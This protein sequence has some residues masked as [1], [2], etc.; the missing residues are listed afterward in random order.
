[1][2]LLFFSRHVKSI[3]DGIVGKVYSSEFKLVKNNAQNLQEL[4]MNRII[5]SLLDE[6]YEWKISENRDK[7]Y[8]GLHFGSLSDYE[9]YSIKSGYITEKK[10]KYI[11]VKK[12]GLP[13]NLI[14]T[15]NFNT[16][17]MKFIC[18]GCDKITKTNIV[19][20]SD[21]EIVTGRPGFGVFCPVR[22]SDHLCEDCF[23]F[24]DRIQFQIIMNKRYGVH[25]EV[26]C[27]SI[28]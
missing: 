3:T 25:V 21:P 17:F 8:N 24:G 28:W 19:L 15:W 1:M 27:S 16:H 20:Q 4:A 5:E 10:L 12:L 9:L 2:F 14:E 22:F 13:K 7:I 11:L 18:N 26:D 6:D 23:Y